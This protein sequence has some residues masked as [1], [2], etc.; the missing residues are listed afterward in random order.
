MSIC[1]T[2][3]RPPWPDSPA[4]WTLF[5]P[6]T[7]DESLHRL[8]RGADDLAAFLALPFD[9]EVASECSALLEAFEVDLGDY[10]RLNRP[11]DGFSAFLDVRL[12]VPGLGDAVETLAA[13]YS[14]W[15]ERRGF[16]SDVVHEH[17][18]DGDGSAQVTL[19]VRGPFAF[20][21]L[22]AESGVHRLA[23]REGSSLVLVQIYPDVEETLLE[24]WQESDLHV[25]RIA[26]RDRSGHS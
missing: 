19:H 11:G 26:H 5:D 15:A 9:P 21:W 17:V 24:E 2:E 6:V 18:G 13:T 16:D 3:R 23:R 1:A 12:S 7:P 10:E 20:G 25:E 8:Q 14:R 4:C 22:R